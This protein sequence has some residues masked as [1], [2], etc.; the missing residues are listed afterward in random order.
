MSGYFPWVVWGRCRWGGGRWSCSP[1]SSPGPSARILHTGGFYF[2]FR[3]A[4]VDPDPQ[5]QNGSGSG[6]VMT[7][8]CMHR[9][10]E[11]PETLFLC[12]QSGPARWVHVQ[13][14]S[15]PNIH[16]LLDNVAAKNLR[17]NCPCLICSFTVLAI[18]D[19]DA[20]TFSV[21]SIFLFSMSLSIL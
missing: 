19:C 11:S 20:Q 16:H 3:M 10:S 7:H 12:V 21:L 1:R 2:R 15:L 13:K 5:W 14:I 17:S 9:G 18:A 6:F 8:A 4:L